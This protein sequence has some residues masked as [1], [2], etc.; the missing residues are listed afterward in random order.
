[1]LYI[2][3]PK[4]SPPHARTRATGQHQIVVLKEANFRL[5]AADVA[6]AEPAIAS[7]RVLL[8]QLDLERSVNLAALRLAHER[9]GA[10]HL[11]SHNPYILCILYVFN[12]LQCSRSSTRRSRWC[13]AAPPPKTCSPSSAMWTSCVRMRSSPPPSHTCPSGSTTC[14]SVT[15]MQSASA[16][17]RSSSGSRK[18]LAITEMTTWFNLCLLHC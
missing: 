18:R 4:A 10:L 12:S 17:V 2:P 5:S 13:P 3:I 14:P 6:R 11:T 1:M 16:R 8:C 9:H 7:A 15:W